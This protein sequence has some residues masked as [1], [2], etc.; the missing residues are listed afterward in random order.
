[1]TKDQWLDQLR[2]IRTRIV[3]LESERAARDA[4]IVAAR[5]AGATYR[6]IGEAGN[7][8]STQIVAAIQKSG[9]IR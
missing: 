8:S 6:E 5:N 9:A 1:M 7:V 3:N 2:A 4:A